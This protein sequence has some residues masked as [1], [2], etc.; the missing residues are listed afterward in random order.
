MAATFSRPQFLMGGLL[1]D[2]VRILRGLPT[3]ANQARSQKI[4]GRLRLTTNSGVSRWTVLSRDLLLQFAC[5]RCVPGFPLFSSF[6]EK[7]YNRCSAHST[8][9]APAAPLRH[10]AFLATAPAAGAPLDAH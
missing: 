6:H 2:G 3:K 7:L 8:P 4:R 1:H 10:R 9:V 5:Y